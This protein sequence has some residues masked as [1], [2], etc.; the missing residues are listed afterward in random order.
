LNT[1]GMMYS[2]S[3][4]SSETTE[5]IA[6]A[7]ASSLNPGHR[8]AV[9]VNDDTKNPWIQEVYMEVLPGGGGEAD[10]PTDAG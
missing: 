5:A 7:A 10:P 2:G 4:S 8:Y 9:R 6:W 3:S 1:L